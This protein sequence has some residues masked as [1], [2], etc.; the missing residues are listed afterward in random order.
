MRTFIAFLIFV[1][2]CGAVSIELK[3]ST[4]K[5]YFKMSKEM[6]CVQAYVY[7]MEDNFTMQTSYPNKYIEMMEE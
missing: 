1:F 6:G 3:G 2:M 4:V 7:I 5:D